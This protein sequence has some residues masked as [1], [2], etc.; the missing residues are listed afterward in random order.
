MQQNLLSRCTGFNSFFSRYYSYYWSWCSAV[1]W[2]PMYYFQCSKGLENDTNSSPHFH[3]LRNDLQH[4][5]STAP[6]D[7]SR[8]LY[9]GFESLAEAASW[10]YFASQLHSTMS[11]S[12]QNISIEHWN[13]LPAR[14]N[15]WMTA[16]GH[17]FYFVK[18]VLNLVT[19]FSELCVV[20]S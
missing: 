10:M 8:H 18:A 14:N 9:V 3:E 19:L 6:I 5:S 13:L 1:Y 16:R 7:S 12:L 15:E 11:H 17:Y 20:N 4:Y 2:G